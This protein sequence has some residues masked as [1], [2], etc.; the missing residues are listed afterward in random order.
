MLL[1]E[2]KDMKE[3][4]AAGEETPEEEVVEEEKEEEVVKEEEE[5]EEK[6]E[7][8]AE[9]KPDNAAY[10]KMRR[11]AAAAKK[12]ADDL[13]VELAV[14]RNRKV[15]EREAEEPS[16][17]PEIQELVLSHRQ[18]KAEREFTALEMKYAATNP[19]YESISSQYTTAL[20]QSIKVQNPRLSPQEVAEKTLH[21][22]LKK[23]SGYINQGYDPIEELFHEAKELGITAKAAKR[24]EAAEEE[25]EIRPDMKKLAANRKRST[26]MG[27]A[28]GRSEGLM[29]LKHAATELT[30]AQWKALSNSEKRRLMGGQ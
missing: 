5:P 10:A 3:K 18:T 4:L 13:E 11:E 19:E 16:V 28:S 26:G 6:E 27:A 17:N 12:R 15:E 7:E 24:E 30:N 22:L 20:A 1:D 2:L 29:S 9:E 25:E 23:A 14:E 8:V 21:T